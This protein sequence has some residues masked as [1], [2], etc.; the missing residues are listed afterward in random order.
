MQKGSE[1]YNL[2]VVNLEDV[3]FVTLGE[4]EMDMPLVEGSRHGS[5]E[6]SCYNPI[7]SHHQGVTLNDQW[8]KKNDTCIISFPVQT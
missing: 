7:G 2:P 1:L 4:V 6:S 8:K 3:G 5:G